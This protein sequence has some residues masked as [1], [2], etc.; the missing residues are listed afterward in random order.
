MGCRPHYPLQREVYGKVM[1]IPVL[2]C[3]CQRAKPLLQPKLPLLDAALFLISRPMI[4][5][6]ALAFRSSFV[7]RW[8]E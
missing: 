7:S 5:V 1:P 4:P 8:N 6:K 3:L 2:R